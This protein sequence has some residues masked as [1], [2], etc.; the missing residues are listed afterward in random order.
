[1]V[2]VEDKQNIESKVGLA[3]ETHGLLFEDEVAKELYSIA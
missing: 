3:L 2:D 1:M